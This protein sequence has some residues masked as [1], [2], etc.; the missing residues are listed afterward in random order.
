M[1]ANHVEAP[2]KPREKPFTSEPVDCIAGLGTGIG[3][4]VGVSK[5]GSARETQS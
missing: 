4:H 1:Q 5:G 3:V 2:F